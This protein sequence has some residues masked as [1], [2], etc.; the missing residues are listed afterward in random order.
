ML[1]GFGFAVP[2]TPNLGGELHQSKDVPNKR[3]DFDE[4]PKD[5]KHRCSTVSLNG[6][7]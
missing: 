7:A 4:C 6:Q 2:P 3:N 5:G 1:I